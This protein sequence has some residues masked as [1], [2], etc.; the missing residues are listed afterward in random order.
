MNI[1]PMGAEF[2]PCGRTDMTKLIVPFRNFVSALKNC[3]KRCL[4]T[5]AVKNR[6][7]KLLLRMPKKRRT[8]CPTYNRRRSRPL[9]HVYD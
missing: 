5:E 4:K 1:H 2:L 9:I 6:S 3:L 7:Q 8:G